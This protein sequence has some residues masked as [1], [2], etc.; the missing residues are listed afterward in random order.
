MSRTNVKIFFSKKKKLKKLT[1][2]WNQ[3]VESDKNQF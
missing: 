3:Q 2:V 1:Q